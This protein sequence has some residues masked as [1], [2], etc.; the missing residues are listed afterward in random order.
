MSQSAGPSEQS[1]SSSRTEGGASSLP[2]G[3]DQEVDLLEYLNAV[4][5]RKY[6]LT[7]AALFGAVMIFGLTLLQDNMYLATSVQ[8][9]NIDEKPGGVAPK[10]YRSSDT[11]GLLERD[12]VISGA[13][14]NERER[15]MARMRSARFSEI[16]ITE[17]NLLPYIFHKQWD[18]EQKD[19]KP[20]FKP[21]MREAIK[22]FNDGMRGI[23][24]DEKTGLLRINFQTRSTELSAELANKF[25]DRFNAY[26]RGLALEELGERRNYLE[27]RLR[28]VQN[29]ELHRSIFRLLETQLAAETLINARKTF[30]LEE[31]QPAVP[32]LIK[33]KPKRL[34]TAAA[35]FIGFLFLGVTVTIGMVLFKKI[36]AGLSKYTPPKVVTGR[37]PQTKKKFWQRFGPRPRPDKNDVSDDWIDP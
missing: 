8:A 31:I 30:P 14:A 6:R 28:E 5:Q 15:I 21:E 27:N 3:I 7:F 23:E 18:A 17:N 34:F 35:S 32:P 33:A 25:V 13:A 29:L 2:G 26:A 16:F 11:I 1:T 37:E 22:A 36:G 12:F 10:E 4:L 24:Y 19:W 20:D 9:I